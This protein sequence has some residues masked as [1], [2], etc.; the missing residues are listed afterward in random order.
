VIV[1]RLE[2]RLAVVQPLQVQLQH[3]EIVAIRMK[4]VI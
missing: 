2:D 3:V 1:D 4:R